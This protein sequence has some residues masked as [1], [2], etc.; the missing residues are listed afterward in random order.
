MS[1]TD[2]MSL[3]IIRSLPTISRP[4]LLLLDLLGEEPLELRDRRE[5]LLLEGNLV[6]RVDLTADFLL[7]AQR[8]FEHFEHRRERLPRLFQR[9][10]HDLLIARQ[11][12]V[13]QLHRVHVLFLALEPQPPRR[14]GE[15]LP[16]A[17]GRHRQIRIRGAELGVDLLVYRFDYSDVHAGDFTPAAAGAPET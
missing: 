1:S 13:E 5:R 8:P 12:E 3:P 15:L 10:E 6:E 11:D 9:L 4:G 7:L 2:E 14:A 17:P 16:L